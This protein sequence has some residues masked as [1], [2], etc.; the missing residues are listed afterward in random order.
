VQRGEFPFE[1]VWL[2]GLEAFIP[3]NGEVL[4]AELGEGL[5][6]D[7]MAKERTKDNAL[8]LVPTLLD[9]HSVTV[10][11]DQLPECETA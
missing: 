7:G 6:A 8:D 3:I 4:S 2:D 1:R 11:L 9:A 10:T 5:S